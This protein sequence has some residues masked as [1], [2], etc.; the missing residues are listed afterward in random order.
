MIYLIDQI[1]WNMSWGTPMNYK[2]KIIST[3][4]K[5]KS[6][7]DPYNHFIIIIHYYY[8]YYYL[9][10]D[11]FISWKHMKLKHIYFSIPL[12]SFIL[13]SLYCVHCSCQ[14]KITWFCIFIFLNFSIFNLYFILWPQ[15]YTHKHKYHN[16][17]YSKKFKKK[18]QD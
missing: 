2:S 8:H 11:F 3:Q 13:F 9:L 12:K 5:N 18:T 4:I 7:S 14:K 16:N 6:S 15:H 10:F 1:F 17:P